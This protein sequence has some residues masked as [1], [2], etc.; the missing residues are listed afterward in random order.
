MLKTLKL[1]RHYKYIVI[2]QHIEEAKGCTKEGLVSEEPGVTHRLWS[3]PTI[4]YL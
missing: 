1:Q 2:K 4:L 3:G